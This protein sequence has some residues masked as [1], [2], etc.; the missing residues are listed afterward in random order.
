[1]RAI[2][3]SILC[4]ALCA[5]AAGADTHAD[6]VDLFA[7][8]AAALS[9]G[10]APGFMKAVDRKMADYDRL[11]TQIAALLQNSDVTNSV[12]PLRDDG[13]ESK[14]SV[15]LDWYSEIR[16]RVAG[17]PLVQRRDVI[18]CQLEKEGKHWRIVSLKPVAF[19]DAPTY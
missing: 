15:D 13:D 8:M 14:R 11:N 4:M 12:E 2:A 3:H 16:S 10:N 7:S 6:I 19:F 1:M 9:D 5:L 17:G 18:H